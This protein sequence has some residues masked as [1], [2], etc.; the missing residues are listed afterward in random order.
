M[1]AISLWQPLATLW[2]LQ[3][4]KYETRS[5][6]FPIWYT[7]QVAIHAAKKKID[8]FD[9]FPEWQVIGIYKALD[10][11]ELEYENLT[12][13]AFIGICDSIKSEPIFFHPEDDLEMDLGNW[14]VCAGRHYW[15]PTNMRELP[16]PI[17]FKGH[18]R[19]FNIDDHIIYGGQPEPKQE[20]MRLF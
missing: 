20:Q 11:A 4:K 3:I 10:I 7:G 13:G 8:L 17:R 19:I 15:I 12:F 16:E 5:W 9:F 14:T 1:K 18:Q 6:P 2:V